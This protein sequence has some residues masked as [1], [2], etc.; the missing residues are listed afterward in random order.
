MAKININKSGRS[1]ESG[2]ALSPDF[3]RL[4]IDKILEEGG[5]R[6][7]REIPCGYAHI[8][9]YFKVVPNTIKKIWKRFCNEYTE[10]RLPVSGGR[11][12]SFS[13]GDLELIE[14]LKLAKGSISLAEIWDIID[15]I[16]DAQNVSLPT[17]SRTIRSRLPSGRRYTRK[18]ITHIASE[19]FTN[20]NILYTQLFVNY[21]NAQ[22]PHHVKFFD[23][24]GIKLSDC[25]RRYGHSPVGERCVEIC[26][27]TPSPNFTLSALC[28]LNGIEYAKVI[29]GA[30]NTV[31][32]LQFFEEAGQSV[33]T[34]TGLPS[35]SVGD[36]I[37]MDNLSSHHYEGG[38]ALEEWLGEMG[39]ELVYTPTY[40]PDLNPIEECFSKIKSLLTNELVNHVYSIKASVINATLKVT[41]SDMLGYYRHTGYFRL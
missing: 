36:L 7:T 32:F 39:I 41:A 4:I 29:N 37:V 31:E 38:A 3:R 13:Q 17:I 28:S 10:E 25:V 1:F 12:L 8:A 26:R 18:K 2:K 21:I 20:N 22:D 30:S 14:V 33:N 35:L 5:D 11:P 16:G 15:E 27:K 19:R 34:T 9:R 24:A 23:E 40:S 6:T